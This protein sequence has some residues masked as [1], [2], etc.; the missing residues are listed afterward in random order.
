MF[1]FHPKGIPKHSR[2]TMVGWQKNK[3]VACVGI[4]KHMVAGIHI[5]GKKQKNIIQQPR[6]IRIQMTG[7]TQSLQFPVCFSL[8]KMHMS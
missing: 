5:K 3:I 4:H 1:F 6:K 8:L 7:D 2:H